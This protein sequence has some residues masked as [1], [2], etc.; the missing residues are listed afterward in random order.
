MKVVDYFLVIDFE[1]SDVV[2][3]VVEDLN[4]V[5]VGQLHVSIE[6]I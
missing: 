2:A 3:R 6:V 1:L 4:T 5:L